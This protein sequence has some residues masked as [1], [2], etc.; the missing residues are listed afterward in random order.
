[1][2]FLCEN[3]VDR[4]LAALI[5]SFD[6][7]DVRVVLNAPDSGDPEIIRDAN[8]DERIIV[9]RDRGFPNRRICTIDHGTIFIPQRFEVRPLILPD[10]FDCIVRPL[11]SGR[12]NSLGHGT[13][14]ATPNGVTIRIGDGE[15]SIPAQEL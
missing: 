3:H 1:M 8:A 6:A 14:T 5:R 7:S 10:V 4:K 11:E 2:R 9:T 13:C 15:E 12:L